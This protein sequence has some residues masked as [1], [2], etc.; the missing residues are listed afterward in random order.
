M[1]LTEF[2]LAG[3]TPWLV[4]SLRDFLYYIALSFLLGYFSFQFP[5]S[6]SFSARPS[7]VAIWMSTNMVKFWIVIPL[8]LVAATKFLHSLH[9]C[10]AYESLF[11]LA[12]LLFDVLSFIA[13]KTSLAR[14]VVVFVKNMKWKRSIVPSG[15]C[16][17]VAS[18]GLKEIIPHLQHIGA[19]L[20]VSFCQCP[21]CA[22]PRGRQSRF[23][24]EI[25]LRKL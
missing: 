8:S 13:S 10:K 18:W 17:V 19:S 9:S 21:C 15:A 22:S 20:Y 25:H 6:L 24:L 7:F 12:N 2:S 23:Y 4:V 1:Y 3:C 16:S 5:H 11:S 14:A